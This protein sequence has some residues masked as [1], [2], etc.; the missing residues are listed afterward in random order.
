MTPLPKRKHTSGRRDRRR[1]HDAL[2]ARNSVACPNCGE[3]RLPHRVCPKC[4]YYQGREVLS[5]EKE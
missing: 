3:P 5:I 2:K 1:S 4:G